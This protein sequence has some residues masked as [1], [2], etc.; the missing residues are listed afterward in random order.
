[1]KSIDNISIWCL[2]IHHSYRVT[3]LRYQEPEQKLV[4]M[5]NCVTNTRQLE[6]SDAEI[7]KLF[8]AHCQYKIL[9]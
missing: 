1:M 8:P 6:R 4:M 5:T 9:D 7:W 2:A 3:S